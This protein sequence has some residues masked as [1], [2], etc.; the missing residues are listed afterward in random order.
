[1]ES[2]F[3]DQYHFETV[4]KRDGTYIALNNISH[5]SRQAI[6]LSKS[7]TSDTSYRQQSSAIFAKSSNEEQ[8]NE[9]EI[10]FSAVRLLRSRMKETL[11]IFET[12]FQ[13]PETMTEL[14]ADLFADSIPMALRNFIGFLTLS[15]RQFKQYENNHDYYDFFNKDLFRTTSK[16]L[17]N[18]VICHDILNARHDHIVSPKHVLLANEISKHGRSNEL[19]SIFNRFG[20]AASYKTISRIHRKIANNQM[21]QSSLPAGLLPN[22]YL[23][24]VADNFDLNRETLHGERSYHFLNRIFVQTS[25]NDHHKHSE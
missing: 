16:S 6:H 18:T 9:C 17:K 24:Q 7:S 10:I 23:V 12:L 21:M 3:P 4:T 5:Y 14:T 1:M 11:H 2:Q 22:C 19:L 13:K 8:T 25:E 20:H 15:N